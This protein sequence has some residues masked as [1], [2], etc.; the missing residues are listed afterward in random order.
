MYRG[1][2]VGVV[3]PAYNEEAH[4]G[5]VLETMPPLVD[6]V[7]AVDDCSTDGT[8][9]VIQSY[10]DRTTASGSDGETETGSGNREAADRDPE[11]ETPTDHGRK[12]IPDGGTISA[13]PD[14]GVTTARSGVTPSGSRIVPIRHE[15]N[16]GAGGALRTG[17]LHAYADGVD[18]AVAMDADGQMDPAQLPALL[19]PIV[20]GVAD[21][22][23]GN[24]LATRDDWREMPPFR[25]FG[26]LLLTGLTKAS[27]G[28]WRLQD[29]QNGYT[30][31]SQRALSELD[32]AAIP[33]DHDYTNDLLV[34][35]NAAGLRVAD[36]AMPAV[37]GDEES[38]IE[39]GTFVRTTSVTLARGFLWRLQWTYRE[40]G[41]N[42]VPLCYAAGVAGTAV[43]AIAAVVALGSLLASSAI[44]GAIGQ[45][46]AVLLGAG[47]AALV[48][49]MTLDI[50][51]NRGLEV[52]Y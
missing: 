40:S 28:Y 15:E 22:A 16:Q 13:R 2:T 51:A 11:S 25:L 5:E 30:A 27:S 6:L 12:P 18:V 38:T 4:I 31:M 34:R 32:L 10:T 19:D 26:N 48:A 23:K 39:F 7:Y 17:Y 41:R 24:R 9:D 33:D 1:H 35:L 45:L 52:K 43:A 37:Y 50:H 42:A 46:A 36:V 47:L 20:E 44:A 21:Y 49:A 8:W 29:P 3:V 14:G